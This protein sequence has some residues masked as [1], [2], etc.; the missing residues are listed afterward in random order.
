MNLVEMLKDHSS[1]VG[2]GQARK[3]VYEL[4]ARLNID[5]PKDFF[6]YLVNLN[7]AE[8]F[9]EPIYGINPE[10][11]RLDIYEQNKHTEH[12]RY[13]F[14]M[15]FSNDIDG[16]I[17]IRPDTSNVYNAS[18]TSPIANSFTEFAANVLKEA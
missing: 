7:Y 18:F 11:K 14:L 16:T 13:G 9:D 3:K 1:V 10:I 12:F 17:Y 5:L 2:Q 15:V 4:E 6:D 8:I